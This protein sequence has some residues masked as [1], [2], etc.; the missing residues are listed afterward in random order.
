MCNLKFRNS[1]QILLYGFGI[2]C[3]SHFLSNKYKD[4]M[5]MAASGKFFQVNNCLPVDWWVTDC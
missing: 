3:F 4:A 1:Q 2:S 5:S